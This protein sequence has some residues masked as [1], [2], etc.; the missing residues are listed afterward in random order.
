MNK[1]FLDLGRQPLANRLLT[2]NNLHKKEF[3]FHLKVQ[4]NTKNYLVSLK[5]TVS[6]KKMFN[7][8]YPY[9]SS[10]SKTDAASSS[11]CVPDATTIPACS[12]CRMA[13]ALSACRT[14]SGESLEAPDGFFNGAKP[15]AGSIST[16]VTLSA[17][18][19]KS[20]INRSN[21][22]AFGADG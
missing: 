9:R 13:Y 17:K 11:T 19:I 21:L 4:F 8:T 2:K 6:S 7:N 10:S 20:N 12:R 22:K 5:N 15:S 3:K 16:T 18:G 14:V 1:T